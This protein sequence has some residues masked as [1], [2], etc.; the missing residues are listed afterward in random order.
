MKRR[1]LIGSLIALA[2]AGIGREGVN[3]QT[4][5]LEGQI[6]TILTIEQGLDSLQAVRSKLLQQAQSLAQQIEMHQSKD[7][8]SRGERRDLEKKLQ[9]SQRL[10]IQLKDL[11]DGIA[12]VKKQRQEALKILIGFY[13]IEIDRLIVS[14]EMDPGQKSE[15]ILDRLETLIID[16]NSWETHIETPMSE[17][18]SYV[19]VNVK[20]WDSPQTLR[21]KGDLLF[22]QEENI[23]QEI[24]RVSQRIA[25]LTQEESVRR[26]VAEL[27]DEMDLFDE[28]EELLGKS[29]TANTEG[30][31]TLQG[32]E[33]L[34]DIP[35]I[36][37]VPAYGL[38][39][40]EQARFKDIVLHLTGPKPRSLPALQQWIDSLQE[41]RNRIQT[42]ADSLKLRAEWF[43]EEA[44]RR[45]K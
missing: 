1:F 26:K 7:L 6:Q 13:Q 19:N 28:R 14:T 23:R 15:L 10:E 22:D 2:T 40:L 36:S 30:N 37:T 41:Y 32:A 33:T 4:P 16:K 12:D 24:R 29:L 25:S 17:P 5:K 11:D 43:Y 42:H 38:E 34:E 39:R 45:E 35:R 21:M 18:Q 27:A 3:A 8:L 20:Q 44:N 9:Q 31:P